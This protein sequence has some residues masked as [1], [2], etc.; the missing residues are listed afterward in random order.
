M[1]R[2]PQLWE[3]RLSRTTS[4]LGVGISSSGDATAIVPPQPP[5]GAGGGTEP[6]PVA[7]PVGVFKKPST[8][9]LIGGLQGINVLWDGLNAD[10]D[11]WPY[12]T[13]FVEVHMSTTG[14]GFT[15]GTATLRGR[16]ARPGALFVG[17]LTAGTTYH[18]RLRGADPAGNVTEASDA[19]TGLTGLTTSSDYGLA[20]IGTGSVSFNA[21][22]IGGV[23]N[24][25]GSATPSS[26]LQ[27][28]VWL[29]NSPGT[30]IIHKVYNGSTWVT[31]AWGSA[32]IAAGQITAL[33]LAVGAVTAGA[34]AADAITGKTITGGTITGS[35]ING[36]T[37][38]GGF[39]SG[40]T[41]S[42]GLV[43]GG[44]VTGATI[45]STSVSGYATSGD[46]ANFITGAQVNGNV[47]S[48]SGGVITTGTVV[49][50][51]IATD[52]LDG[53]T[54]T[55]ATFRTNTAGN[56][57]V[58]IDGISEKDRVIWYNTGDT[59]FSIYISGQDLVMDKTTTGNFRVTPDIELDGA[60]SD[61]S[62]S[63]P[64]LRINTTTGVVKQTTHVNSAQRFKHDIIPLDDTPF[65]GAVD[66]DLLGDSAGQAVDP[67]DVLTITPIQYRR[68]EAPDVIVTG[69]LAEDVEQ[70][71]PTAAT[72]DDDG[73][74]ET[75][76]ERA[77]VAA[78]LAVVKDQAATITDLRTR[79]EALE[80]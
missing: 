15:L 23:T 25:V 57:R 71:F 12:D 62:T 76:D 20:S 30:A 60:L 35:R 59:R 73:V 50:A 70:K 67:A 53:K 49:A 77:I 19:A 44:T 13:S 22:T 36:G 2:A 38:S 41:V 33:Q 61:T 21:R 29:D 65:G 75:I 42:G 26:P 4:I 47:T 31:N 32:S 40:G 5:P 78:L 27:G 79:I 48:I 18:F 80:A 43:S 6:A 52:A 10:G 16:L 46:I 11:L 58:T 28:D 7:P 55:G 63:V 34:I 66:S 68:N 9:Q 51:R 24:T 69:F 54:I 3:Q 45:T 56:N 14:T 64:N 17:G 8:P 37:I 1:R 74:L 39:I 72:Y